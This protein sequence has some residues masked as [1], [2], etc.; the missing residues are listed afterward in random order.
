MREVEEDLEKD[1]IKKILEEMTEVA[2]VDLDQVQEQVP[3]ETGLDAINVGNT[4]TLQK[5]VQQQNQR[6]KQDKYSKCSTW[7]KSRHH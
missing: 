6:R 2:V 1:S 7:M 5:T 4:T 3:I